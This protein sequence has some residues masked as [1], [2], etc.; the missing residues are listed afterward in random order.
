MPP[1]IAEGIFIYLFNSNPMTM[2][3][4]T[5]PSA[6]FDS[7]SNVPLDEEAVRQALLREIPEFSSVTIAG[8]RPKDLR[9]KMNA[10]VTAAM[11]CALVLYASGDGIQP[12]PRA[13]SEAGRRWNVVEST[14]SVDVEVGGK[15]YTGWT[16]LMMQERAS[17]WND[18]CAPW[19]YDDL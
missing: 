7:I 13:Q 17:E 9:G 18:P 14:A 4:N 3:G 15:I 19:R 5:S 6:S 11:N 10:A 1:H 2:S 16:V 12:A 8:T